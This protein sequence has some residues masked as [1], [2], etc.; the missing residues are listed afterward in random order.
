MAS[1]FPNWIPPPSRSDRTAVC[2]FDGRHRAGNLGAALMRVPA[3]RSA[4]L[5]ALVA[6]SSLAPARADDR[7]RFVG[8]ATPSYTA[9]KFVDGKP[10]RETYV[11]AV[12]QRFDGVTADRTFDHTTIREIAEVLAPSLTKQNYWPTKEIADADLML[13]LHWGVTIPQAPTTE[14]TARTTVSFDPTSVSPNN[15]ASDSPALADI[16]ALIGPL[17]YNANAE[18]WD[19]FTQIADRNARDISDTGTA[20]LLGYRRSLAKY[21]QSPRYS[22]EQYTLLSDLRGERYFVIVRAYDLRAEKKFERSQPLWSLY[23]NVSSPGNNF[24][25]A[26]A[27]MSEA[28]A[29]HFGR[30]TG[31]VSTVRR[32]IREGHVEL[33]EMIIVGEAKSP[34]KDT[35]V[36]GSK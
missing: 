34:A 36:A 16:E 2:R 32:K 14:L 7:V 27:L 31:D 8:N 23:L 25:D 5:F 29:P 6:L 13:V 17:G 20:G 10:R 15:L 28:A 24:V 12:G 18:R 26:I 11:F 33:G 1:W 4:A 19:Q 21:G 3:P 30:N 9:R 22:A 35:M